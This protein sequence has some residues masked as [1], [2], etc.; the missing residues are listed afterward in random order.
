MEK[1]DFI[2]RDAL[3]AASVTQRLAT[4]RVEAADADV[5]GDEPILRDGKVVGWVT[6]GGFAHGAGVSVALGYVKAEAFD[7]AA[8]YRI[9]VI[10]EPRTAKMLERPLFDPDAQRMRG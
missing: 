1:G 8:E 2:G 7:P 5:L 10:G 4:F 9:E 6:S 3:R